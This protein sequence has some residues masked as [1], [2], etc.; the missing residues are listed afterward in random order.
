MDL[1]DLVSTSLWLVQVMMAQDVLVLLAVPFLTHNQILLVMT[2]T[3]NQVHQVLI[4]CFG[5][6]SS[7]MAMKL[8]AVDL[9]SS[10]TDDI[11]LRILPNQG[12]GDENLYL[13]AYE[14]YVK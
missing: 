11:E 4:I 10:T 1:L 3:A 6:L 13:L 14:F 7:V 12:F 2:T 8:I 9:G 5:M